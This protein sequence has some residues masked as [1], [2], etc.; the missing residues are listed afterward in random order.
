[1]DKIMYMIYTDNWN[2]QFNVL[3]VQYILAFFRTQYFR[4][5]YTLGFEIL[6]RTFIR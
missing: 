5:N 2:V 3:D 6:I 4:V 1:M